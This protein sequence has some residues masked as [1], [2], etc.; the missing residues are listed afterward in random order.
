VTLFLSDADLRFENEKL[1]A[2]ENTSMKNAQFPANRHIKNLI[3][4]PFERDVSFSVKVAGDEMGFKPHP[5][6]LSC[7]SP[8]AVKH[9]QQEF[10]LGRAAAHEALNSLLG[11]SIQP[12]LKG[13][14]GEPLWPEGIVGAITH[15]QGIAVA[16][17]SHAKLS[18]GLGIDIERI[19]RRVSRGISRHICLPAEE[20]WIR[21]Q[22]SEAAVR[23]IMLFSAKESIFK[24]CYPLE[25][26]F[27]NYRDAELSWEPVDQEFRCR[28]R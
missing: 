8:Q 24:A 21:A 13:S 28:L 19:N 20:D 4:S 27:L 10:C 25:K 23:L 11:Q 18:M 9:R 12:I 17:V 15:S 16:A 26:V 14:R 2:V 3:L 6:E 7:L 5:D 22:E 1:T